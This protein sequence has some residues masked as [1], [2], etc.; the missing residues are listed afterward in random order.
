MR[1][2]MRCTESGHAVRP[3]LRLAISD[4]RIGGETAGLI[5]WALEFAHEPRPARQ[6]LRFASVEQ[7]AGTFWRRTDRFLCQIGRQIGSEEFP[8]AGCGSKMGAV[9][10]VQR[11]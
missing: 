11:R 7:A 10:R 9:G 6:L 3:S 1:G 2:R 4:T 8:G 5:V